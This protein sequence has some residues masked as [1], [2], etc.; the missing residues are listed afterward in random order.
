M[1]GALELQSK[2]DRGPNMPRLPGTSDKVFE[3]LFVAKRQCEH[4][5]T[6]LRTGVV[7]VPLLGGEWDSRVSAKSWIMSP[8]DDLDEVTLLRQNRGSRTVCGRSEIRANC[9]AGR[10]A[11]RSRNGSE[12]R[13]SVPKGPEF[14]AKRRASLVMIYCGCGGH[15]TLRSGGR[16]RAW[17]IAVP[18]H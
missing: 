1:A 8:L 2:Q 17:S 10:V 14:L 3:C 9:S 6:L 11:Q 5:R 16:Y 12:L 18:R 4:P 15:V 13:L 7:P